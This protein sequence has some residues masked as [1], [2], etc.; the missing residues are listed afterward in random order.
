MN[1]KFI[2]RLCAGILAGVLFVTSSPVSTYADPDVKSEETVIDEAEEIQEIVDEISSNK[3][4]EVIETSDAVA[5]SDSEELAASKNTVVI[6]TKDVSKL[7]Y[8]VTTTINSLVVDSKDIVEIEPASNDYVVLSDIDTGSYVII[9]DMYNSTSKTHSYGNVS[10]NNSALELKKYGQIKTEKE[11]ADPGYTDLYGYSLGEI[12]SNLVG[13][14]ASFPLFN[15]VEVNSASAGI[16]E[17]YTAEYSESDDEYILDMDYEDVKTVIYDGSEGIIKGNFEV[18]HNNYLIIKC[19][20]DIHGVPGVSY[21]YG[22]DSEIMPEDINVVSKSGDSSELQDV[23][24]VGPV[25]DDLHGY[26][27]DFH[28]VYDI[29]VVTED[30]TSVT[31]VITKDKSGIYRTDTLTPV[32]DDDIDAYKIDIPAVPKNFYLI[33]T[34]IKLDK[35][36]YYG[37][38]T[39]VAFDGEVITP[40]TNGSFYGY[41]FGKITGAYPG[42]KIVEDGDVYEHDPMKTIISARYMDLL[43]TLDD[44]IYYNNIFGEE[45]KGDSATLSYLFPQEDCIAYNWEDEVGIRHTDYHLNPYKDLRVKIAF[46]NNDLE[47]LDGKVFAQRYYL[48]EDGKRKYS[49]LDPMTLVKYTD[50]HP[51]FEEDKTKANWWVLEASTIQ[52]LTQEWATESDEQIY[53]CVEISAIITHKDK[54]ITF[55]ATVRVENQD[56]PV[57]FY[58]YDAQ[59]EK[60]RG[61]KLEGKIGNIPYESSYKFCVVLPDV[62]HYSISTVS[63]SGNANLI[64]VDDGDEDNPE[65]I[66]YD[67]QLIKS[68][69]RIDANLDINEIDADVELKITNSTSGRAVFNTSDATHNAGDA[70][71]LGTWTVKSGKKTVTFTV[72]EEKPFEPIVVFNDRDTLVPIS[73]VETPAKSNKYVYTYM[74]LA[75]DITA[76]GGIEITDQDR[77]NYVYIKYNPD[78]AHIIAVYSGKNASDSSIDPTVEPYEYDAKK[79]IIGLNEDLEIDDDG[80]IVA[81]YN[82]P[83]DCN[84]TVQ[85]EAFDDCKVAG[86]SVKKAPVKFDKDGKYSFVVFDD[87]KPDGSEFVINS[88]YVRT[89]KVIKWNEETEKYEEVKPVKGVYNVAPS[90]EFVSAYVRQGNLNHMDLKG[91][92]DHIIKIVAKAGNVDVTDKIITDI[93]YGV[94]A[95]TGTLF[96]DVINFTFYDQSVV[97]KSIVLTVTENGKTAATFKINVAPY[98]S[99]A[100]ITGESKDVLSHEFLTKKTYKVK[101]TPTNF[102]PKNVVIR[103]EYKKLI[104]GQYVWTK[105][106]DLEDGDKF[107]VYDEGLLTIDASHEILNQIV[108]AKGFPEIRIKFYDIT[109][110]DYI[111]TTTNTGVFATKEIKVVTSPLAK[112]TPASKLVG[113]SDIEF[114]YSMPVPKNYVDYKD[115]FYYHFVGKTVNED[116]DDYEEE[117]ELY[118]PVT[119]VYAFQ[120]LS[121]LAEGQGRAVKYNV[122]VKLLCGVFNGTD[123]MTNTYGESKLATLRNQSTKVACYEKKIGITAKNTKFYKGQQDVL[124]AMAKYS[125]KTTRYGIKAVLK[126]IDAATEGISISS[127]DSGSPLYVIEDIDVCLEDSA[128][129]IPGKYILEITP[130]QVEID[131]LPK[132]AGTNIIVYE[133]I[134]SDTIAMKV[135]SDVIY[136]KPGSNASMKTSVVYLNPEI[137]TKKVT[138]SIEEFKNGSG[139]KKYVSVGSSGNVTI[140]KNLVIDKKAD[141]YDPDNFK[142]Y[143]KATAADYPGNDASVKS[144]VITIT[145]IPASFLFRLFDGTGYVIN[146]STYYLSNH[147]EFDV[148]VEG[149]FDLRNCEV[150]TSNKKI[151][152]VSDDKTKVTIVGKGKV[153]I[154]V[155]AL[156]GSKVSYKKTINIK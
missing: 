52:L 58:K 75:K 147:P 97:G 12:T 20:K 140:S 48:D 30:I 70:G 124:L 143:V 64:P 42:N 25:T 154:T 106:P 39:Y 123:A 128:D 85:V 65:I 76:D 79:N 94:D 44:S 86:A 132:S 155:T 74:V 54:S 77:W 33:F 91:D 24:V 71:S 61:T 9:L 69:I 104:A 98:A 102:D 31:Y 43:V 2:K 121:N 7:S 93:K 156:D 23:F 131:T 152:V 41:S 149:G 22:P 38:N 133:S 141:D 13:V 146:D 27:L 5:E 111:G 126:G 109:V 55:P 78:Q 84:L 110:P 99:K 145:N 36:Y 34:N 87:L 17:Y 32:Y 118:A 150:K 117:F 40:D 151:A 1:S 130:T 67:L 108:P 45:V 136:Q 11:N 66:Y 83:E 134:T 80:F 101:V 81:E 4:D 68:D 35:K 37:R 112:Y 29:S 6:K 14:V 139:I 107:A 59:A 16:V 62:V 47:A 100:V 50:L 8:V 26:S 53:D 135:A 119:D 138:Y 49:K 63:A 116:E 46:N 105:I 18:P 57:E 3:A 95:E 148:V 56:V 125:A 129:L 96:T 115:L 88:S 21:F 127:E 144:G 19:V 114:T 51:E 103:A 113:A 153:T 92:D 90:D 72:T 82:V 15:Y 73:V 89:P 10:V 122:E 142:F 28:E 120:K 137:H 60:G